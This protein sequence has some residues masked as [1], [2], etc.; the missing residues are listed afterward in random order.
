H[1]KRGDGRSDNGKMLIIVMTGGKFKRNIIR[2]LS[3][4][5]ICANA[6]ALSSHMNIEANAVSG[7]SRK[8][9]SMHARAPRARPYTSGFVSL[10]SLFFLILTRKR[11][12]FYLGPGLKF[13][14]ADQCVKFLRNDL[15]REY[16]TTVIDGYSLHSKRVF[17][18]GANS[19][20]VA[21]SKLVKT[22]INTTIT[23]KLLK[24]KNHSGQSHAIVYKHGRL[25]TYF[26]TKVM[27]LSHFDAFDLGVK[28]FENNVD[29]STFIFQ[30]ATSMF[31]NSRMA[32]IGKYR[33]VRCKPSAFLGFSRIH[34]FQCTLASSVIGS[35][36]ISHKKTHSKETPYAC[37]VCDKRFS[38]KKYSISAHL[39]RHKMTHTG[40]KPF[41]CDVC[42]KKFHRSDGLAYTKEHIQ[43]KKYQCD[44]CMKKFSQSRYLALH[45]RIHTGEKAYECVVCEKRFHQ[46]SGLIAHKRTH[47]GER[48]Y[49]CDICKKTFSSSSGLARHKKTH[50]GD[51]SFEC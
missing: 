38:R 35:N 34:I 46:S 9:D 32:T 40:V 18:N 31:I 7:C 5:C 29:V 26:I 10:F 16:R 8:I 50:G 22:A 44:V 30:N 6:H 21:V 1:A 19:C 24:S 36:L 28:A 14:P 45:K 4:G 37:D 47:T 39:S 13:H 27:D 3:G 48:P 25:T 41:A 43:E 33:D 20:S 12:K 49:E 11:R 15:L 23:V 17:H 51:K 2:K 42:P